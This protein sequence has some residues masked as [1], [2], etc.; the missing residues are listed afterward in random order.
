MARERTP[1]EAK[2]INGKEYSWTANELLHPELG[3]RMD[4][5]L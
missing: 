3:K 4:L 2:Q 5:V 1:G